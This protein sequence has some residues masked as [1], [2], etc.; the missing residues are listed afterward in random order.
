MTFKSIIASDANSIILNPSEFAETVT[1][2]KDGQAGKQIQA[3]V[4]RKPQQ[5]SSE[6]NARIGINDFEMYISADPVAGIDVI[7]RGK[8]KV[9]LAQYEGISQ[10]CDCLVV[11]VLQSDLGIWHLVIRK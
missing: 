6:D 5:P 3:I 4:I 2:T 1:Y 10:M 11:E 7:R 9:T 8:D